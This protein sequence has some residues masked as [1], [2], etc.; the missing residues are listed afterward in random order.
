[1][2]RLYAFYLVFD[3]EVVAHG[4]TLCFLFGFVKEDKEVVA[5]GVTLCFLFGL[6]NGI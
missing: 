5:H 3:K 2:A 1:M 4:M 6:I